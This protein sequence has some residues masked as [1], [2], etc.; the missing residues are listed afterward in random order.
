MQEKVRKEGKN[1]MAAKKKVAKKKVAKK[2]AK[3]TEKKMKF[4]ADMLI[5]SIGDNPRREGSA[6]Y[7]RFED[8]KKY[9]SKNKSATVA[10]VIK[11][12]TAKR[13]LIVKSID[14][15]LVK[16]KKTKPAADAP[17]PAVSE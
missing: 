3:K 12:T 5:T 8:M 16:T 14:A 4:G 13:G 7:A 2:A 9:V 11:N 17:A 1:I 10:D 15:G 6:A